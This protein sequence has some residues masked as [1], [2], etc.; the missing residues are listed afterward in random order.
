MSGSRVQT[1]GQVANLP[2]VLPQYVTFVNPEPRKGVHVFARIAEVLAR[3]RP[4]IPVLLVE[5]AART[6][7]LRDWASISGA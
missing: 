2:H 6:T 7:C 1:V 5:G 3:R 4:D